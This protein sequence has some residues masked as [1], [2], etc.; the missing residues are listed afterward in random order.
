[1]PQA[2]PQGVF[3]LGDPTTDGGHEY[4]FGYVLDGNFTAL[5]QPI[6]QRRETDFKKLWNFSRTIS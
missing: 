2:H 6:Y 4:L 1:M 5:G 3:D